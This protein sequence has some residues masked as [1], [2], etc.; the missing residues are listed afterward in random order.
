VDPTGT[1]AG[2]L[3]GSAQMYDLKTCKQVTEQ[4]NKDLYQVQKEHV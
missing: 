4:V 2:I 3:R 1:L